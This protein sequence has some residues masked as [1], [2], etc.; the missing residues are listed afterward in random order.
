M[1]THS[2]L[3]A[4]DSCSF[5][6]QAFCELLCVQKAVC[7]KPRKHAVL[8]VSSSFLC[9]KQKDPDRWWAK[10]LDLA[11]NFLEKG[12]PSHS[13]QLKDLDL[14]PHM[15]EWGFKVLV[16]SA[17]LYPVQKSHFYEYPSQKSNTLQMWALKDWDLVKLQLGRQ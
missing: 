6:F 16:P 13:L 9:R 1:G 12:G 2:C 7:Y 10:G 4:S 8:K 14:S 17:T 5:C 15:K 11:L 3:P